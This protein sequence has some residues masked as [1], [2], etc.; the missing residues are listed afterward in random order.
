MPSRTPTTSPSSA[1]SVS[2]AERVSSAASVSS[3]KSAS[4]APEGTGQASDRAD[5]VPVEERAALRSAVPQDAP[6]GGPLDAPQ[7]VQGAS[8]HEAAPLQLAQGLGFRLSR[9]TRL[10][11]ARWARQ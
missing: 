4:S 9:L 10:L 5:A 2:S 8:A 3:P 7:G 6:H 1:A 11:R